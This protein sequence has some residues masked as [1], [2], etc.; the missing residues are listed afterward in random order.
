MRTQLDRVEDNKISWIKLLSEAET[1]ATLRMDATGYVQE[2]KRSDSSVKICT[3]IMESLQW[4]SGGRQPLD[5]QIS[6]VIHDQPLILRRASHVQVLCLGSLHLVGGLLRL[7]YRH[8]DS[9]AMY[10][11]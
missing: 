4:I 9:D 1:S 11:T 10:A 7:L 6:D 2:A 8:C 3:S 5:S